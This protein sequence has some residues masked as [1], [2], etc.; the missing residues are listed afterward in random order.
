MDTVVPGICCL[1]SRRAEGQKCSK[2]V[3]D[4]DDDDDDEV[5]RFQHVAEKLHG[6]VDSQYFPIVGTVFLLCRV[7]LLGEECQVLSTRCCSTAPM[8]EMEASVTSASC[9]V[10]SG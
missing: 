5:T 4:D 8:P 6:L 7:E 2:F 10:G 3:D 1:S 9:A